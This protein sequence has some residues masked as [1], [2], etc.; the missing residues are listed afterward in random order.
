MGAITLLKEKNRLTYNCKDCDQCRLYKS[1]FNGCDE[2]MTLHPEKYVAIIEQWAKDVPA[3]TYRDDFSG[4]FPKAC[5]ENFCVQELYGADAVDCYD[6]D[7]CVNCWNKAMEV[8]Y[9]V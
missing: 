1:G 6:V 4:K 3:I 2:L 8:G 9:E 5:C 7:D